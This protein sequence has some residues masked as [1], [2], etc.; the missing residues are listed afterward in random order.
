MIKNCEYCNTP[1]EVKPSRYDRTK[2]CSMDCRKSAR[3]TVIC[4]CENCNND[5][6]VPR[7]KYNKLQNGVQQHLFCSKE[8]Q[9]NYERPT[10]EDLKI[11]FQMRGYALI[12]NNY[13]NAR[14]DLEYICNKHKDN[15]S[16]TIKYY[17]FKTGYGCKYCGFE[18]TAQKSRNSFEKVAQAFDDAGLILLKQDYINSTTPLAYICK[19]H[20]DIGIQYKTYG[21][22]L[23]T[24]G[25]PHCYISKGERIIYNYLNSINTIFEPQKKY[26]DLFGV[27]GKRLSYD[28]Y[29]PSH[30][31]LIEYQGQYHDGTARNQTQEEFEIQKEHDNRKKKYAEQ[32]G[33]NLLEIWYYDNIEEKLQ[34]VFA[35]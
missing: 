17:N 19:K 12:S 15:G 26:D 13:V 3:G 29:I 33:I 25:C 14:S 6:K 35:N 31:L 16:Q 4:Q 22:V 20:K 10:I 5:I 23:N 32:H 2:F 27:K 8:C 34:M 7:Y 28:F 11:K 18:K 9:L 21:N 30:N 1:F 24:F